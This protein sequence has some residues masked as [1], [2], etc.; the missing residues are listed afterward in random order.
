M[1]G[2]PLRILLP[3]DGSANAERALQFALALA[4]AAPGSRLELVNVQIPVG[5]A[6]AAF[7]NKA[8]IKD[9]HR[10]EGMKVLAPAIAAANKAGVPHA[11]H[12]GVGQPGPTIAA[13]AKKL[14]GTQIVMGT[15]GLGAALGLLLGSVATEVIE[16]AA[17]PVTLVK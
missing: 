8:D 9:F 17:V 6:V 12:I 1:T 15:R 2:E 13:F 5:G 16:N 4:Q 7:V 10:D 14:G 11:H 3:Y